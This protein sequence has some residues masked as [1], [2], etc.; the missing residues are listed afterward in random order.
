MPT[1]VDGHTSVAEDFC[2]VCG[3]PIGDPPPSAAGATVQAPQH[4]PA[5]AAPISGRFCEACGHDS[6]L[7]P[8][9]EQAPPAVTAWTA[10]IAADRAFYQ[11]VLAREGPDTVDF[12]DYFPE[13]R[14]LL[15]QEVTLIGRRNPDKGVDPQIDL[16]L[17]PA[18]RGVST[19]HAVLRLRE[20]GLTITDIGSTNGTSLNGSDDRLP[21]GQETPLADGDRI[22][23]G[24]WTT[25]TVLRS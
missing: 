18:D 9:A 20:T 17:H 24:A 5:C 25:I 14:I 12:P 1:C 10:V 4:C 11:R 21:E 23:V 2:D 8:P 22:H 6:A 16:A 15:D 3:S 7:P 13:R 19:Q